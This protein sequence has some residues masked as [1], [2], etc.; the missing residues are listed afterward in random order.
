MDHLFQR[1]HWSR[2]I[3]GEGS[4][5]FGRPRMRE[6]TIEDKIKDWEEKI[7]KNAIIRR[8]WDTLPCFMV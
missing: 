1:F 5:S 2:L 3:W 6:G 7:F 8:L 4:K